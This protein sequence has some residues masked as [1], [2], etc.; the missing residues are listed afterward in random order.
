MPKHFISSS[1]F[2]IALSATLFTPSIVLCDTAGTESLQDSEMVEIVAQGMGIDADSALRNAYSN[3][4]Q[5]A[6][7]LYVDAETL[8]QNDQLVKDEVLTHSRGLIKEVATISQG[9]QNGLF[10]V[11]VR[12]QVLRQPLIDKVKPIL[13][14]TAAIDGRSL[15]AAIETEK[16]QAQDAQALLNEAIKP[17]IG[18]GLF[19]FEFVGQPTLDGKDKT[20]LIVTVKATPNLALYKKLQKEFVAVLEQIATDKEEYTRIVEGDGDLPLDKI[21]PSGNANNQE[22]VVNTWKSKNRLQ[23]KWVRYLVPALCQPNKIEITTEV[24]ILDGEGELL[25]LGAVRIND[26][27]FSAFNLEKNRKRCLFSPDIIIGAGEVYDYMSKLT[28]TASY[29]V[30]ITVDTP[31]LADM[32]DMKLEVKHY[33]VS[34]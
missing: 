19:N 20:K 7:G 25:A 2:F 28:S 24:S 21:L 10:S 22:I 30:A 5:Q 11:T 29:T 8:V 16:K 32:K 12:A 3:A 13:K 27:V 14:T 9:N 26:A 17:L 18:P 1:M 6:L 33:E 31:V 4:I 34:K 15:H 23:S